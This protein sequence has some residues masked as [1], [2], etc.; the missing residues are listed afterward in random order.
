MH[1]NTL[2]F[3]V[4][5][6]LTV[7]VLAAPTPFLKEPLSPL[8]VR[9][10]ADNAIVAREAQDGDLPVLAVAEKREPTKGGEI[11]SGKASRSPT[12]G[13]EIGSGKASRSPTKGGEIGSGKASRSPTKGGEIGSGKAS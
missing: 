5:S 10:S 4:A 8:L 7:N 13:G 9:E 11:G 12:K 2:L 3:C 6:L 1:T